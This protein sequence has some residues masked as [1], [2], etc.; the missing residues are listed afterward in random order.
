MYLQKRATG[1]YFRL[2]VPKHLKTVYGKSEI[3]I[4]LRTHSK[5]EAKIKILP[6]LNEYFKDFIQKS[7]LHQS[8][9]TINK[10]NDTIIH[11]H[12]SEHKFSSVFE[13]YLNERNLRQRSKSDF[14]TIITRFLKICGDKDISLYTKDDVVR[15]KDIL[16]RFPSHVANADIGL[17]VYDLLKKYEGKDYKKISPKTVKEKYLCVVS[18]IFNYAI[19]NNY[20]AVNPCNGVNVIVPPKTL[21]ARLPFSLDEIQTILRSCLFSEQ[22][23]E[24]YTEYKY[25]I[26]LGLYT[27]ARLEELC[28]LRSA[29]FGVEDH[30][31]YIHIQPDTSAG[32]DLK[33]SSSLRRVPLHPDLFEKWRLSEYLNDLQ[34]KYIFPIINSGNSVGGTVSLNFSKWF[35]RFLK[36]I[37]LKKDGMCFH[38]FRHSYKRMCRDAGVPKNIYDALQGHSSGDT[39]DDYG[40]D[41]YG[42]GYPLRVLYDA[43]MKLKFVVPE[44]GDGA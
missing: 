32:H 2:A 37:N 4:S 10:N 7:S 24:K 15:Y 25:V 39:S 17:S 20:V 21:P 43:V 36:T 33:T 38:S 8:D 34:G 29:D 3:S 26:L 40:K 9:I 27:G 6:L 44:H 5:Q 18:I 23:T 42:S 31:R 28:K 14:E 30:I 19:S 22:Q 35:R 16:L 13:K 41:C 1:Y 11:K 12:I